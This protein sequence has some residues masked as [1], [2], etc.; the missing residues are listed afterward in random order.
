MAEWPP[1]GRCQPAAAHRSTRAGLDLHRIRRAGPGRRG[2]PV[3]GVGDCGC[4]ATDF[5]SITLT[6]TQGSAPFTYLPC[7]SCSPQCNSPKPEIAPVGTRHS[8]EKFRASGRIRNPRRPRRHPRISRQSPGTQSRGQ[9]FHPVTDPGHWDSGVHSPESSRCGRATTAPPPARVRSLPLPLVGARIYLRVAGVRRQYRTG[10][11]QRTATVWPV[12]PRFS[13][14]AHSN[15]SWRS[16]GPGG[17]D[18]VGVAGVHRC[19]NNFPTT[20]R[21]LRPGGGS[22]NVS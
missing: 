22:Q 19:S 5:G 20:R 3:P 21:H 6:E 13:G 11:R 12:A 2:V 7:P 8:T 1:F 10:R 4:Y 16:P 9:A 17:R 15:G 14:L 18:L